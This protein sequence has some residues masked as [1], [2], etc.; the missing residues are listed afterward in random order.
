MYSY[1]ILKKVK[2]YFIELSKDKNIDFKNIQIFA[3]QHILESQKI[4]FEELIDLGINPKN[5]SLLGKVYSTSFEILDEIK[6]LGVNIFQP[7]FIQNISFD[8][9]HV[10]NCKKILE[11]YKKEDNRQKIILDDGG[12]LLS[13]FNEENDYDLYGIEQTSSGFRKLEYSN[14]NFPIYNVAR[15]R[16]KLEEETPFIVSLGYERI[17]EKISEYNISNPKILVVGMGPIGESLL[18]LFKKNNYNVMSYDKTEGHKDINEIILGNKINIV[19]GATGSEIINHA[20]ILD[21]NSKLGDRVYFISMSS[22]DR[23]FDIWKLR[24]LFG[25]SK[26]IHSDIIF[27]NL[28]IIN[29]GFPITFKGNRVESSEQEIEKTICLLFSGILSSILKLDTLKGFVDIPKDFINKM[30]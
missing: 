22:S 3:C 26:S 1:P 27:K 10:A 30:H 25:V 15:S 21:L 9:Q 2:A 14:I 18:T 17:L 5:I 23:E 11:F 19:I 16:I 6:K 8:E 28:I 20:N 4:M 13:L 12:T 7:E 29:N 24:D